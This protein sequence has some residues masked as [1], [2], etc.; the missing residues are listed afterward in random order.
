MM[1]SELLHRAQRI[2]NRWNLGIA[3]AAVIV[4]S[5]GIGLTAAF[6]WLAASKQADATIKAAEMQIRAGEQPTPSTPGTPAASP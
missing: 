4:A 6:G 2:Q 3:L 5:I 1:D